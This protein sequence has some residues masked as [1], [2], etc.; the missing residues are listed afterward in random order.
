[1]TQCLLFA[2]PFQTA[3]EIDVAGH[4]WHTV[5]KRERCGAERWH[6]GGKKKDRQKSEKEK[7]EKQRQATKTQEGLA[8]NRDI[9]TMATKRPWGILKLGRW[10]YYQYWK[11]NSSK[12]AKDF[13]IHRWPLCVFWRGC[14]ASTSSLHILEKCNSLADGLQ[15]REVLLW[16]QTV[17]WVLIFNTG[18]APAKQRLVPLF[19]SS[20]LHR[21]DKKQSCLSLFSHF[22]YPMWAC[23]CVAS[24]SCL[25]TR[26][27]VCLFEC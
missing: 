23:M 9:K 5:V 3:A 24:S 12:C 22:F 7:W 27:R 1:M 14:S 17:N 6:T 16:S 2:L 26:V 20:S 11:W 10:K 25:K 19:S 13:V 15:R 18:L 8:D 21:E 4:I